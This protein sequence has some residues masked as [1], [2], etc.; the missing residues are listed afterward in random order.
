MN[1]SSCLLSIQAMLTAAVPEDPQVLYEEINEYRMV[2][3]LSNI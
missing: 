2:L 1:M 3:L